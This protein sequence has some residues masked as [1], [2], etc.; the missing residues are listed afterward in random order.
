[1]GGD[2]ALVV[3]G[4]QP[5]RAILLGGAVTRAS[6]TMCG[7]WR[8]AARATHDPSFNFAESLL[9]EFRSMQLNVIRDVRDFFLKHQV[10]E[11]CHCVCSPLV[12]S[13]VANE[14]VMVGRR[15]SPIVKEEIK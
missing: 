2:G 6:G 9:P 7:V 4:A 15:I 8:K 3:A 11:T 5:E 13:N 10:R 1:M 12:F 14:D